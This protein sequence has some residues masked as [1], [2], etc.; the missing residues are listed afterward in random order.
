MMPP[1]ALILC[2]P[3]FACLAAAME[4]HQETLFGARLPAA[5]SRVLR[6]AGWCA[7]LVALWLA[8][9]G[10]GWA[11][12]LVWYGGCTILAAGIVYGV[13]IVYAQ[14]ASAR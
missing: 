8:V 14:R 4:R 3:A 2:V 13:L 5:L 10:K 11:P 6:C 1:F 7:L 9:A 12:G